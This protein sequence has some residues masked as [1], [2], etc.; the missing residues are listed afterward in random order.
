VS[1]RGKAQSLWLRFERYSSSVRS[2]VVGVEVIP[3][4]DERGAA[5][6]NDYA[7]QVEDLGHRLHES[8]RW[9]ADITSDN[10]TSIAQEQSEQI[11]RLTVVTVIFLPI[12][13]LTGLYGMNFT[14]MIN[15]IGSRSAFLVLGMLLPVL[16]VCI[17]VALFM[18]R[19]LLF[20]K[21]RPLASRRP[22]EVTVAAP[23]RPK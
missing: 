2:A 8:S 23:V 18:R 5:E 13:F 12:T 20:I 19:G 22:F 16:S 6:L 10:A 7:D 9:L 4:M 11:S 14:W 21:R 15:H 3:G 17:T 1:W